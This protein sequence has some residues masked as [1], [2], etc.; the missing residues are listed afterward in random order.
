M[1]DFTHFYGSNRNKRLKL[2][3][4]YAVLA[5]NLFLMAFLLSG[6]ALYSSIASIPVAAALSLSPLSNT[7][8]KFVKLNTL[9]L[10]L[11]A[12][13]VVTLISLSSPR[14]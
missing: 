9:T 12:T 5:L 8:L 11:A 3:E 2:A 13:S 10:M 14:W 6:N 7:N 1:M 4:L